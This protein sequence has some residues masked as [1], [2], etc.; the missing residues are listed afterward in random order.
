MILSSI[1]AGRKYCIGCCAL[2][3]LLLVVLCGVGLL[4]YNLDTPLSVT[5]HR[6]VRGNDIFALYTADAFKYH[7]IEISQEESIGLAEI[8]SQGGDCNEIPVSSKPYSYEWHRNTS[9]MSTYNLTRGYFGHSSKLIFQANIT[10]E[11]DLSNCSAAI[12]LFDNV[13]SYTS[14][15]RSDTTKNFVHRACFNLSRNGSG[16]NDPQ[17]YSIRKS[18]YLFLGLYLPP[19]GIADH[20]D[21]AISGVQSYYNQSELTSQ[22]SI[23]LNNPTCSSLLSTKSFALKRAPVCILGQWANVNTETQNVQLKRSRSFWQNL[24]SVILFSFG[25]LIAVVLIIIVF[26]STLYFRCR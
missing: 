17:S 9:M 13:E 5:V 8:Y 1:N 10:G 21:L 7:Q 2:A 20:A 22:C 26:S 14:F 19:I 25:V 18:D 4:V 12:Y 24:V 6:E 16:F 11:V 15:L 3:L 23:S